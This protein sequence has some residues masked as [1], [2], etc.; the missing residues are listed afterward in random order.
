MVPSTMTI[1][2][3]ARIMDSS[4]MRARTASDRPRMERRVRCARMAL[5]ATAIPSFVPRASLDVGSS[6]AISD[7]P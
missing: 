4:A 1:C 6:F 2:S 7:P 5:P 3:V